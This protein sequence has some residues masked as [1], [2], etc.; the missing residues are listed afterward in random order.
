MV[1][2]TR[3]LLRGRAEHNEKM[4]SNLEECSLHQQNL[5]SMQGIQE[6]SR[7]LKILLMQNNLIE[8]IESCT[9]FKELEYLNLAVNSVPRIEGLRRCES[10]R[11]LDMTLNFLDLEDLKSSCEELEWNPVISELYLM[12]NPC[13]D[14]PD[15]PTYII[16]KVDSINRLDGT[17]I[18]KSMRLAAK[19]KLEAME[20][21]LEIESKKKK[22]TKEWEKKEGLF[23]EGMY[24][25]E[26][27]W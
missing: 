11:K 20:K 23:K 2:V 7:H 17:D 24:T 3:D 9:K 1:E 13:L 6:Y 25:R 15:A 18:T 19:N 8:K 10:L 5:R 21:D 27:R 14:W 26:T 12:G 4:L 16:A 22:D